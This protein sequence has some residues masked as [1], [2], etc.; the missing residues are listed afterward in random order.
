MFDDFL[1]DLRYAVRWLRANPGFTIVVALMLGLGIGANTAVFSVMNTVALRNLPVPNP[2]QLVYLKTT[3]TVA[4]SGQTGEGRSSFTVYTFEQLRQERQIFSAVV[5]FV[6]LS[7]DKTAVRYGAEPEEAYADMVSGNFFSGL[8]V[9]T[10]CGRAFTMEDETSHAQVA[11]LSDRYWR[12]RFGATCSVVGQTLSVRG[13]PFTIVGVTAGDFIGVE[14]AKAT[15][16]WVPLQDRLDLN[17]WGMREEATLYG[18]RNWWCIMMMGRL[19]PGVSEKEA[20]SKI[21]PVF[22]RAAYATLGSPNRSEK[23]PN[24]YFA[25]A[26]GIAGLREA[27]EDPLRILMA[28]VGLVLVI[29]C[30]N[31]GMLLVA[32]NAARQREFSVRMA[33]GG[34]RSRLLRQLLT[35]SLLLVTAGAALAW[36]FAMAATRALT[37]WSDLDVS[38]APDGAVLL[39]TLGVSIVA[40]LVFGLAPLRSVMRVPIGLALKT[41]SAT[42]GQDPQKLRGRKIVI[43]LQISLCLT[44]L[45]GSGLLVRSLNNLQN[46]NLGMRTSGLLVFGVS[47]QRFQSEGARSDGGAIRFYDTLVSRLRGMAGVESVT[48]MQNRIG[49][50]WSNNTNAAVDGKNPLGTTFAPMRWNAVGAEYFRTLGTP[51]RYG[52]DITDADT[53]I[54]P[55]VAVVN[56]AFAE[57]YLANQNPLG[58]QIAIDADKNAVQYTIVGVAANS[59]YTG[60]REKDPPLAYFPYKQVR[61][62]SAMHV[63]LRTAG[64]P[65]ARLPEVRRVV[66]EI[67]PDLPLLRPTTQQ[68]QFESTFSDARLFARLSMFFGVLAALLVAT[69]LY[70]TLSYAVSRRTSEVGI[71]LALGARRGQ[72]LWMVLGE[73]LIMCLAGIVVGSPLAILCSR[74]L[75]SMLF[76]IVPGDPA[77]FVAALAGIVAVALVASLLPARRAASIDPMV[78]LRYE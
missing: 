69:G 20:L 4:G 76:G 50:G 36:V 44:L 28:M 14:N 75:R 60:V 12:R 10:V 57:R 24:L 49:T 52:R 33:I 11:V 31:V 38:L 70:G 27:V 61:G 32:R 9:R 13:V 46:I 34:S 21:N 5:A 55:K 25:P 15:D 48:L 2:Q 16:I 42:A 18:M 65:L 8:G 72:V 62:I 19:A 78:A 6:P 45:M 7:F 54:A 17:A 73:S 74:L 64:N 40:A 35:E 67:A 66:R 77:T 51:V 1:R 59:K 37:A 58:H 47:P 68:E 3:G 53:E 43:A 56:E 63:E 30:G 41:S 29:A 26:R 39:F 71:R 23:P 22:Q